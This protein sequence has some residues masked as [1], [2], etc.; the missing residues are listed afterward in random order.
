MWDPSSTESFE[1]Y[2]PLASSL[3]MGGRH[4]LC[5]HGGARGLEDLWENIVNEQYVCAFVSVISKEGSKPFVEKVM[6]LSE[7]G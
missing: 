4:K 7:V 5:S 6:K 2:P 1:G 3:E